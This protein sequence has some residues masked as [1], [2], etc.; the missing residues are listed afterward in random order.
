V[1]DVDN[2][3]LKSPTFLTNAPM[4][5][6]IPFFKRLVL[7]MLTLKAASCSEMIENYVSKRQDWIEKL[8]KFNESVLI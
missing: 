5:E 8:V 6:K 3:V 7:L 2:K 4:K 1:D